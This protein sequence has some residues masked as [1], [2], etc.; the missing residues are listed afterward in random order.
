[1]LVQQAALINIPSVFSLHVREPIKL[2]IN[3]WVKESF[4]VVNVVVLWQLH[5]VFYYKVSKATNRIL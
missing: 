5:Y 2:Q 3:I 4:F 1:M